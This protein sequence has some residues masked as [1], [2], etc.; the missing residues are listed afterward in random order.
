MTDEQ[1]T[2][3]KLLAAALKGRKIQKVFY[4]EF[5][6]EKGLE[7]WKVNEHVHS[8]DRNLIFELDDG[9]RFQLRSHDE[10]YPTCQGVSGAYLDEVRD[11]EACK[12]I[13]VS[14]HPAWQGL[15]SSRISELMVYWEIWEARKKNDTGYVHFEINLPKTLKLRFESGE[16]LWISAVEIMDDPVPGIWSDSLTLAF[17]QVGQAQYALTESSRVQYLL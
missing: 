7:Y 13:E 5:Q 2:Y 10:F 16:K 8:V 3:H 4:E 6:D 15:R 17:D 14:D 11:S 12:V 9:N 1:K